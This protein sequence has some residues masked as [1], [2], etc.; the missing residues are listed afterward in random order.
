[1]VMVMTEVERGLPC[2][3]CG[4]N[5][6]VDTHVRPEVGLPVIATLTG[7]STCRTGLYE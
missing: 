1:M 3:R 2:E 5:T 6:R 7:C 4:R